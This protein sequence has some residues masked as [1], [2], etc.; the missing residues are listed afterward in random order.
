MMYLWLMD[1][2]STKST[3]RE[4]ILTL[5]IPTHP[6]L[7]LELTSTI[8]KHLPILRTVNREIFVRQIFGLSFKFSSITPIDEIWTRIKSRLSHE[9]ASEH[10]SR[11]GRLSKATKSTKTCGKRRLEGIL[12]RFVSML[13]GSRFLPQELLAAHF[14]LGCWLSRSP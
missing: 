3:L 10:N 8:C 14:G 7:L 5:S 4:M 2:T 13:Q 1:S 9:Q 12:E 6:V 11:S